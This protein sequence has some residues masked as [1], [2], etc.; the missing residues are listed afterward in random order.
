MNWDT[1]TLLGCI[2]PPDFCA[3]DSDVAEIADEKRGIVEKII[4]SYLIALFS[5]LH[6]LHRLENSCSRKQT[7]EP[8]VNLAKFHKSK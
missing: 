8:A 1:L 2:K 6:H 7:R 4:L 3:V 5:F